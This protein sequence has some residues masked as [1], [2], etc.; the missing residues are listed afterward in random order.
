MERSL[1]F[2][3]LA[4]ISVKMTDSKNRNINECARYTPKL[5]LLATLTI[6]AMCSNDLA[7]NV[8]MMYILILRSYIQSQ[9][10]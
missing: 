7:F 9:R 10:F 8:P 4:T 3:L 6:S 5:T 2:T 1:S